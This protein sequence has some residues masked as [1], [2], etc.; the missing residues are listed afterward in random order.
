MSKIN[1]ANANITILD[2]TA[3][4]WFHPNKT[5]QFKMYRN[6]IFPKLTSHIC[7]KSSYLVK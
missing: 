5:G 6:R 2:I 7:I 1:T 4:G 3:E